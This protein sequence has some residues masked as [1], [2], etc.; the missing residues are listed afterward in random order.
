MSLDPARRAG[1]ER[2]RATAIARDHF[3]V[4][5]ADAAVDT[6]PFGVV[7]DTPERTVVV[8][9]SNDLA[10][11]GGVLVWAAR[12][13][14]PRIEVVVEHHGGVHARRAAVLAPELGIHVLDGSRLAAAAASPIDDP[15]ATPT[16]IAPLVA[17][18]ERSGADAVIE[19]G[20]VRAEVAGL[21]VGRVVTGPAGS[22]FEVGVGRFDRE[23]GA[24]LHADRPIE[25]TLVGT[26]EKVRDQRRPGVPAHPINRIGRE[27]WLRTIV[28]AD[29]GRF[30]LTGAEA[31]E[32]VPPRSSLL[33]T[34]PAAVLGHAGDR[35]V[36]AVCTVGADLGL[37]PEIADLVAVHRPDEVRVLMP[38]RDR[39]PYVER[40]IGLLPVAASIDVIDPP[41]LAS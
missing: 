6:A 37:V 38:E 34:R 33:E 11:L 12:N 25:P 14:R 13:P 41:W 5:P 21:E 3:D 32:P 29:P 20:I 27:R 40:L 8:S 31:V 39:L 26:I 4:D 36:L 22:T 19:D 7:V 1:L 10:V 15:H 35:R 9:S 2:S 16:D 23:A 24:L 28:L 30:G 17:M 18:I